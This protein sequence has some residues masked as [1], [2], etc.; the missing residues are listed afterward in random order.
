MAA[1]RHLPVRGPAQI[2]LRWAL[3]VV[4][5]LL[6]L[7]VPTPAGIEAN[8]W[9]LLAIFVA[10]MLGLIVQPLPGGAMVLLARGRRDGCLRRPDASTGPRGLRELVGLAGLLGVHDRARDARA[11]WAGVSRSYSSASWATLR[12]GWVM[13]FLSRTGCWGAY[14]H[15]IARGRAASSFPSPRAYR[16]ATTLARVPQQSAWER[17]FFLSAIRRTC[18]SVPSS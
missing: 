17:F 1:R 14:F 5:T 4:P 8:A 11:D 9:R 6:V 13:P 15:P 10:T 18:W 7:A 12:W 16:R 2:A 3:V